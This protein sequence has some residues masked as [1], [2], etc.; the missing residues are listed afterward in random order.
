MDKKLTNIGSDNSPIIKADIDLIFAGDSYGLFVF[1]KTEKLVTA[2]YLLTGLMSD[3]EPMKEKLRGL[4]T[5]FLLSALE[6]SE[7]IW[8]E[9]SF[10]KN[11]IRLICEISA[12]FDIAER[13]KMV[14]KMNY[15]ILMNELKNLSNFLITSSTNYS[16][17]KIAFEPNLFDG[18]YNYMPDQGTASFTDQILNG[19][20]AKG[21]PIYK[22]QIELKD[23]SKNT[24][25][26]KMPNINQKVE[27]KVVKDKGNR[28][29]TIIS[30]L[31]GGLKL[32]IKDFAKNIKGCSEKTIQRE[33]IDM[34][35]KG[36]LKKEGE[37]RWSKY[38]LA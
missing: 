9:E 27:K 16:S 8:G 20:F 25:D 4:A 26:Q 17:A 18:N 14:S 10:Q 11:L 12:F 37:R 22:G 19:N 36:V 7:R 29:E 24:A 23:N 30:M 21:I 15:T 2:I 38:F 5:E 1:K 13:T 3:K 33:L 34:V 28:Q 35:S 6:M 31:K 32:T